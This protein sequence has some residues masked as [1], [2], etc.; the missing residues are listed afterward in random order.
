MNASESAIQVGPALRTDG[1]ALRELF[2]RN[3]IRCHCRYWHFTGDKNAWLERCAAN[4]EENARELVHALETQAGPEGVVA[5]QGELIVAWMKLTSA[6]RVNKLYDQRLYKNLPCFSEDRS[7]IFTIGCFFV[8]PGYRR[9]GLTRR[10]VAAGVELS[11][12][13]GAAAVEA[14]PR[15]AE[16]L[17]DEE[18]W[19]GPFSAFRQEGFEVVHDFAPYPVLRRTL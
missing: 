9:Q 1:A 18:L 6:A 17:A 12:S 13:A 19:T 5:R 15:R 2:E 10:L 11:R 8:D 7:R 4:P 16:L 3:D 14:F